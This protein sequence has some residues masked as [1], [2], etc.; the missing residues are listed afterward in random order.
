MVSRFFFRRDMDRHAVDVVDGLH[1]GFG[2]S[3]VGVG[4]V[5]KLRGRH[6]G[7]HSDRRLVDE[8]GRVV[9]NDVDAKNLVGLLLG[10]DLHLA[11]RFSGAHGFS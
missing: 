6:T 3:R 9:A 10:D 5:A 4:E 8:V 7:L 1:Y 2:Q 11:Y